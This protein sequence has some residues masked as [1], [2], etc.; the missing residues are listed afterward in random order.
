ME[1]TTML[2]KV[3]K[4]ESIFSM[5]DVLKK[6]KTSIQ[7]QQKEQNNKRLN[8]FNAG[9]RNTRNQILKSCEQEK[10]FKCWKKKMQVLAKKTETKADDAFVKNI[11]KSSKIF[12]D[13]CYNEDKTLDESMPDFNSFSDYM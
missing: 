7:E 12:E 9:K 3:T 1:A 13:I 5:E 10:N 6:T 8:E 4:K 2:K 11:K